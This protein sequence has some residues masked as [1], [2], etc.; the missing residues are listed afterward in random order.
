MDIGLSGILLV[1]I[2]FMSNDIDIESCEF[3]F[4]PGKLDGK[5]TRAEKES[6]ENRLNVVRAFEYTTLVG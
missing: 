4:V 5:M 3:S 6:Q 1:V 2:I